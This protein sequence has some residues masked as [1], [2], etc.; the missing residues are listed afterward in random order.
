MQ[1]LCFP[2]EARH[3]SL[4]RDGSH[5]LGR[6]RGTGVVGLHHLLPFDL[7]EFPP[8]GLFLGILYV[9]IYI[10]LGPVVD[11][12]Q[13]YCDAVGLSE[14]PPRKLP[15][16]F[17]RIQG[18]LILHHINSHFNILPSSGTPAPQPGCDR[19]SQAPRFYL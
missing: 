10:P 9:L 2:G 8:L 4:L 18:L 11:S 19:R 3:C 14:V 13:V 6:W 15:R 16:L 7:L 17:I 12:G 5:G 1:A